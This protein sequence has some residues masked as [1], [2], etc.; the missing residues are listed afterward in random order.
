MCF[1]LNDLYL[2]K[3]SLLANKGERLLRGR[4]A[5]LIRTV[6]VFGFH[7]AT[8]DIR[9]HA[10]HHVQAAAE[11]FAR[12]QTAE[13]Y[14]S[15][16]ESEKVKI[17]TDEIQSPRAWTGGRQADGGFGFSDETNNL[18]TLFRLIRSA[19]D[20]IGE[21]AIQSYVI[22]M[23]QGVSNLLEVLLLAQDAELFGRIDIVYDTLKL[24]ITQP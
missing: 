24:L 5:N 2:I 9:Q 18:L 22:S 23:T 4:F 11:V 8:L 20:N 19:Q 3:D 17:L 1:E 21:K 12:N 13:D 6:E 7:L 14:P 16:S 15:L 10:R